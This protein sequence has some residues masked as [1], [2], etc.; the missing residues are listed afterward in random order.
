[1]PRSTIQPEII[2]KFVDA[3]T[4]P[5]SHFIQDCVSYHLGLQHSTNFIWKSQIAVSAQVTIKLW[6]VWGS[7]PGWCYHSHWSIPHV[8]Q[9]TSA[10][11][12]NTAFPCSLIVRAWPFFVLLFV[13]SSFTENSGSMSLSEAVFLRC[14]CSIWS[15]L[16]VP[17]INN[18]QFQKAF[19]DT[20]LHPVYAERYQSYLQ[21]SVE[22]IRNVN[23]LNEL[24]QRNPEE[25]A[26][27]GSFLLQYLYSPFQLHRTQTFTLC[28]SVFSDIQIPS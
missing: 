15:A 21:I 12:H 1:M 26:L 11:C 14:L 17:C 24:K 7:K 16:Q 28:S 22:H 5:L 27:F 13:S 23:V 18:A 6:G 10:L 25:L 2:H 19:K 8:P 20:V 9:E 4:L 3:L